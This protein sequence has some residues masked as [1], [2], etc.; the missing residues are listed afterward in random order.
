MK[1]IR[2]GIIVN[3]H[4][5]KGE[6]KV[7]PTTDFPME[8][9]QKGKSVNVQYQQAL[10]QLTIKHV[11]EQKGMLL[12]VFEG[13]EDINLVEKWKGSAI[14]IDEEALHPLQEDEIYFYE[15]M[16]CKVYDREEEYLGTVIEIIETGA[17]AVLR[18]KKEEQELLI[19]YVKAFVKE[20]DK[21]AKVLTV[22]L[23]DG[24]L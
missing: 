1:Q 11:R 4:G 3:T 12:L 24:M 21:E 2:I 13:Y 17:N 9:Y 20:V 7:K 15:L 5:L 18:V 23:L 22:E 14:S 19:P 8:R 10:I 16:D 6:V